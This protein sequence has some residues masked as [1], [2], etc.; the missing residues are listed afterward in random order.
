MSLPLRFASNLPP[1][2]LDRLLDNSPRIQDLTDSDDAYEDMGIATKEEQARIAYL[3][4]IRIPIR[5]Q[6]E[7]ETSIVQDETHETVLPYLES[8]PND[9]FLNTF[10]IPGLQRE[11]HAPTLEKWLGDYPG[12]YAA[13]DASRPWIV[14][15]SL[16]SMTALG[17]DVSEYRERYVV[18]APSR[19]DHFK[20]MVYGSS[21]YLQDNPH[22]CIG[23]A[24]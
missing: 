23:A 4:R 8:N 6:L 2:R 21:D 14:Y 9:F 18:S 1:P 15:W 3:D 5:D 24:S 12:Q 19:Q 7:T 10:N 17:L 13:M 16:Q 22:L 20:H 11:K